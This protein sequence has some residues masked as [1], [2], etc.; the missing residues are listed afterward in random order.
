MK[1]DRDSEIEADCRGSSIPV[2]RSFHGFQ[3]SLEILLNVG[4]ALGKQRKTVPFRIFYQGQ[5]GVVGMSCCHVCVL[6][7]V[8][9]KNRHVCNFLLDG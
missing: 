6:F 7:V 5:V 1:V 9:H 4:R 3:G 8:E 2:H